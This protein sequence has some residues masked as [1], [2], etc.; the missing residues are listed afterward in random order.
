MS[1]QIQV[2]WL[3]DS[4]VITFCERCGRQ[5]TFGIRA[6]YVQRDLKYKG[7]VTTWYLLQCMGCLQPQ[8]IEHSYRVS[9][10]GTFVDDSIILIYPAGNEPLSNLPDVVAKEYLAALKVQNISANACAVLVRRTLEVICKHENANGRTLVEKINNLI[11]SDCIPPR[12]AELAHLG[13]KIGNLG[14]HVEGDYVTD[15]DVA[16]LLDFVE[17]I[18]EYLYIIPQKIATVKARLDKT[19]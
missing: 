19:P 12:L 16:T 18:L 14:A 15:E 10:D 4:Q 9:F 2:K 3:N 8:L 17:T 13:R 7:D 1:Y 11:R 6:D 5:S